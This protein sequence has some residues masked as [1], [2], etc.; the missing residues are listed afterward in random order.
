MR[1]NTMDKHAYCI[2]AHGGWEQ[3]Q[4]LVNAL[5]DERN[6]I[7]LHIDKKALSSY[8]EQCV[9]GGVT[10]QLSRLFLADSLDVRWGDYSLTIAELS[11]FQKVIDNGEVY[12]R[13][14]LI[15]GSDLPLRSQDYIHDFF[16]GKK[17]EYLVVNSTDNFQ[18]RVKYYHF[19]V[20]W[21]RI[22]PV[23]NLFRR[24]L[25]LLQIPFVNRLKKCPL[26]YSWGANWCSLTMKAVRYLCANK[27]ICD[28]VFQYT[29][30]SDELYKQMILNAN[31][32]FVFSPDEEG[33]MR[34][35][36]FSAHLPSPK[37]LTM[38]DYDRIMKSGRL[39]ARKF[40]INK[41]RQVVEKILEKL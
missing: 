34:Y 28:S 14:H 41:D 24:A 2:M 38:E 15:S 12:E 31:P 6:D 16:K 29:T 19:Y 40:D 21:L 18:V 3:L 23:F 30:S 8:E 37:T 17:E 9:W 13:I 22:H 25:L 11:L 32:E 5:D 26:P 36:D 4:M 20:R 27:G 7:Y 1:M 35:V 39:F 10:T 33:N